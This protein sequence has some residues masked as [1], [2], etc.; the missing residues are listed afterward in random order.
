MGARL[1]RSGDAVMS[2]S[3]VKS[4]VHSPDPLVKFPARPNTLSWSV[5]I[6]A[7]AGLV[8]GW[9]PAP[10]SAQ[11]PGT[12]ATPAA[13]TP[14]PDETLTLRQRAAEYWMARTKRDYRAQWEL[15]EPR[16]K[17]RMSPEQYGAGKGAIHYLGYEVGDAK[18]DGHFATVEVKVIARITVA[19]Q[20]TQPLVRTATVNDGWVKIEGVWYRRADQPE[21]TPQDSARP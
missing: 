11:A 7:F 21:G 20:P 16:L 6:A 8:L 4:S 10:T 17:G 5:L 12:A 1:P 19:S 18:I 3:I 9:H 15:S 14:A 2:R 13:A